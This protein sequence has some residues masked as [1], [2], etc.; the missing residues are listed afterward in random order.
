MTDTFTEWRI[1][2]SANWHLIILLLPILASTIMLVIYFCKSVDIFII[3]VYAIV[4]TFALSFALFPMCQYI[5]RPFSY[6]SRTLCGGLFSVAEIFSFL[7]ALSVVCMWVQTGHWLFVD[8]KFY[9]S[10]SILSFYLT[11]QLT[12]Q[13][14][15]PNS[16]EKK[17]LESVYVLQSL[18]SFAC[19][20]PRSS[21]YYLPCWYPLNYFGRSVRRTFLA[22]LNF[23]NQLTIRL[24]INPIWSLTSVIYLGFKVSLQWSFPV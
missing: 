7:L 12:I 19:P 24:Y 15:F 9:F 23:C 6:G 22:K 21:R 8:G 10:I 11:L 5:N 20:M 1:L 14:L 18:Q 13:F 17:L 16:F 4:A 3:G 2:L